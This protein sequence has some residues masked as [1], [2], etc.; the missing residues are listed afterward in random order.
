MNH[1]LVAMIIAN[2]GG[3]MLAS[4]FEP[5]IRLIVWPWCS[6]FHQYTGVA[7]HRQQRD[8]D[9][10]EQP[11]GARGGA[12]VLDRVVQAHHAEI[13]EQQDQFASSGA[14]PSPTTCPTSAC[15]RSNRWRA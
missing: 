7:D 10:R 6:E 13:E 8:A 5:P 4:I 9:D 3:S 2:S 15:P 1:N 14:D 11:R 12:A